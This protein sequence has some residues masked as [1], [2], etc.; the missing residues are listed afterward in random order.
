MAT[1]L[2]SFFETANNLVGYLHTAILGVQR[3]HND[4]LELAVETGLWLVFL[5]F[6]I[7]VAMCALIYKL[8]PQ[9]RG[10]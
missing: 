8:N 2:G 5:F 3:V 10:L 9:E 4:V 6:W 1:G 7:I